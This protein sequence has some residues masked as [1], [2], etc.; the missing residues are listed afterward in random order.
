[1]E[2]KRQLH[3]VTE[4]LAL[5]ECVSELKNNNPYIVNTLFIII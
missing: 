2:V 4:P 1:M 3:P 5:V